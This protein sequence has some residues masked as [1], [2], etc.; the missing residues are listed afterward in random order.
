MWHS[1]LL[2]TYITGLFLNPSWHLS[3]VKYANP[4]FSSPSHK[5]PPICA[6]APSITTLQDPPSPPRPRFKPPAI[7]LKKILTSPD[8]QQLHTVHQPSGS[9]R[10]Q[11]RS[12]SQS[13]RESHRPPSAAARTR[14][15]H[16]LRYATKSR[17]TEP[18]QRR[19]SSCSTTTPRIAAVSAVA[20]LVRR[21]TLRLAPAATKEPSSQNRNAVVD[22]LLKERKYISESSQACKMIHRV[23][24]EIPPSE[25]K[26]DRSKS[27]LFDTVFRNE[28]ELVK[29]TEMGNDKSCLGGDALSRSK[30]M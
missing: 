29:R 16:W 17:E 26:G 13:R 22:E 9:H 7:L 27:V 24:T 21:S 10:E 20:V 4:S 18:P 6:L 28:R 30:P 2:V 14:N 3:F 12:I 15:P 11:L 5:L 1:S 8:L 25:V 23:N 19:A